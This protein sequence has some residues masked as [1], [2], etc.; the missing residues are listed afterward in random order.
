MQKPKVASLPASDDHTGLP[1]WM[2]AAYFAP[3]SPLAD[4][5]PVAA[6]RPTQSH[7]ATPEHHTKPDVSPPDRRPDL[8]DGIVVHP[9]TFHQTLPQAG[10]DHVLPTGVGPRNRQHGEPK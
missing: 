10:G 7:S 9:H 1:Q 5:M 2:V 3:P 4:G 8:R 6:V